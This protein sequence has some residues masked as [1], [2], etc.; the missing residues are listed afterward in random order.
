VY[1]CRFTVI[2]GSR[3]DILATAERLSGGPQ[4]VIAAE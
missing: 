2:D 3:S 1:Y 4:A